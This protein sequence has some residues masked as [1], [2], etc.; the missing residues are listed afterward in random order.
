MSLDIDQ[1]VS[2][3]ARFEP[4]HEMNESQTKS[5]PLGMHAN[6]K[7]LQTERILVRHSITA[8]ANLLKGKLVRL[9]WNEPSRVR[10]KMVDIF[11]FMF[12]LIELISARFSSVRFGSV[13]DKARADNRIIVCSLACLLRSLLVEIWLSP[14]TRIHMFRPSCLGSAR[15]GPRARQQLMKINWNLEQI[16]RLERIGSRKEL[17]KFLHIALLSIGHSSEMIFGS[18]RRLEYK[19]CS[20]SCSCSCNTTTSQQ[21]DLTKASVVNERTNLKTMGE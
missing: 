7:L 19:A 13:F 4:W 17:A 5:K 1:S 8:F 10:E 20:F 14:K 6:S 3:S 9:D 15:P 2:L 16:N 18:R 12:S 11:S 21:D